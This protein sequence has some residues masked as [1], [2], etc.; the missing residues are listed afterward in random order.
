MNEQLQ[1]KLV[2]ILA[3][4]QAATKTAGDFAMEQLPDIAQ[5][6]IVYGRVVASINLLLSIL[7]VAGCAFVALRFG[8]L[9]KAGIEPAGSYSSGNWQ[10]HRINA[11][12]VGTGL[13]LLSMPAIFITARAAALVW[14]APKVWLLKELASLIK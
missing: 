3:G 6:Y 4:I 10:D 11:C 14:L 7:F 9:N 8:Y 13:G 12:I 1:S 2:E 5:Q